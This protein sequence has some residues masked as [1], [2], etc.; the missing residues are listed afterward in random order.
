MHKK[1]SK[2]CRDGRKINAGI[3]AAKRKKSTAGSNLLHINIVQNPV[4]IT[5]AIFSS[6][7]MSKIETFSSY[8]MNTFSSYIVK[9]EL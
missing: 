9:I 1:K 3:K 4:F 6:I 8:C 2:I 7:Y 5:L